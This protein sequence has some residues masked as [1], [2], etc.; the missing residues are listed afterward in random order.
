MP[1]EAS[2]ASDA[3]PA[4]QS[5]PRRPSR[6][7]VARLLRLIGRRS[8]E[9]IAWVL[10]LI[11]PSAAGPPRTD[12]PNDEPGNGSNPAIASTPAQL[13]TL[14]QLMRQATSSVNQVMPGVPL[15]P[16]VVELPKEELLVARV[17]EPP[18]EDCPICLAPLDDECVKTPCQHHFHEDCLNDYF[19][20]TREP[21]KR[22]SCP[23]CRGPV[24]VPLPVEA[25]A[26]SGLPIEVVPVPPV[27]G[28]CHFDRQ[29]TFRSLGGF[30][31]PGTLYVMTCNDDR[32]TP[33]T[34]IM[35]TLRTTVAVTVYLNFRS[36][37]HAFGP[38]GIQQ[39][40]ARDGWQ[41]NHDIKSTVSTGYPN[42]PY[43]G[44]VFS[45]SF[46]AGENVQL[47]GS[48]CWEGTYFVF[49]E[50]TKA[51]RPGNRGAGERRLSGFPRSGSSHSSEMS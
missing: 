17:L 28:R 29:Y 12:T 43:Y 50:A 40:L 6:E 4:L 30:T 18:N 42:G 23:L 1:T 24:H 32:K 25:T 47:M 16:T 36:D 9:A 37:G 45:R 41:R 31:F 22:A 10:R 11:R 20:R 27:G 48:N 13:M 14:L 49:V 39:W 15:E 34:D 46:E 35:W 5:R 44:P 38:A 21:G 33:A 2:P 26:S 19:V 3:E 8:R 7:A 51:E